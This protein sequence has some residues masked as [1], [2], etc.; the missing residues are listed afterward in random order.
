MSQLIASN[1]FKKLWITFSSEDSG[2]PSMAE[3]FY[4][5]TSTMIG[6]R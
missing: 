2:E 6:M 3:I 4:L 1:Y 5:T